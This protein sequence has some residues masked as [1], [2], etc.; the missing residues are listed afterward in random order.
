[1]DRNTFNK[2]CDK[3]DDRFV[4][5]DV[6]LP[7][8]PEVAGKVFALTNAPEVDYKELSDL[9]HKDPIIAGHVIKVANSPIYTSNTE[10]KSLEDAAKRIGTKLLGEL[11]ISVSM[12]SGVFIASGFEEIIKD[13][14]SHSIA[15]AHWAKEIAGVLKM[16][17][18]A[19]FIAGMIH[20]IGM[21]A[22]LQTI[23]AINKKFKWKCDEETA[24]Y[25]MNRYHIPFTKYIMREWTL[26]ELISESAAN[27]S[28]Y[29]ETI[30]YK[31]NAA[32]IN[33]ANK[34]AIWSYDPKTMP[35]AKIEND[36]VLDT[37]RMRPKDLK[38]IFEKQEEILKTANNMKF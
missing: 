9:I 35:E 21:P 34:L 6:V 5:K 37:L 23:V 28:R 4:R 32:V 3:I 8:L 17:K 36:L 22:V 20:N 2:Y 18:D 27:Y 7:V 1:M 19:L 25:L 30:E 38:L 29:H 33:L 16:D 12:K 14:W 15:S 13:L 24:T 26:P 31:K 10:I 11:A